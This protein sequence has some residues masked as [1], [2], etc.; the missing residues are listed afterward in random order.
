MSTTKIKKHIDL[1][2]LKKQNRDNYLKIKKK[3]KSDQLTAK[4]QYEILDRTFSDH[5]IVNGT[6]LR[7]QEK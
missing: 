7:C 2:E 5:L 1:F 3:L 6:K 4:E